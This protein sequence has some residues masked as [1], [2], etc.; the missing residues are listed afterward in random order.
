M[1]IGFRIKH[2]LSPI[3]AAATVGAVA[4]ARSDTGKVF[5]AMFKGAW[6]SG[7]ERFK[8]MMREASEN[9]F[10]GNTCRKNSGRPVVTMPNTTRG[11]SPGN[12]QGYE[13]CGL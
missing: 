8:R 3:V 11:R 9:G 13:A 1:F 4:I 2:W 6:K 12:H 5:G 7:R 10:T